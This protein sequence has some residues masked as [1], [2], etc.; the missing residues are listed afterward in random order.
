[1]EKLLARLNTVCNA[2]DKLVIKLKEQEIEL[3]ARSARIDERTELVA[4]QE[5]EVQKQADALN[6]LGSLEQERKKSQKAF[7][8]AVKE[9]NRLEGL[10]VEIEN[11]SKE[12]DAKLDSAQQVEA[13][14]LATRARL[15]VE[16]KRVEERK[17]N[18]KQ[19]I[20]AELAGG[21]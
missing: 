15:R 14:I 5:R 9:R 6:H 18:L 17:A 10:L 12:A 13:D 4:T 11:K 8:K 19:E 3:E 16:V 7:S 1:M 2:A 21:A 20:M